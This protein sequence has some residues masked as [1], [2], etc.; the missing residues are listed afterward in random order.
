MIT[1]NTS[2]LIY[3]NNSNI[4]SLSSD[5]FYILISITCLLLICY[6]IRSCNKYIQ[7]NCR[8]ISRE[9]NEMR[10]SRSTIDISDISDNSDNNKIVTNFD[11]YNLDNSNL[12]H[13]DDLP[14]YNEVVKDY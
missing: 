12:S 1:I 13:D 6:T 7:N 14:S 2:R 11:L 10:L 8:N 4:E 3:Q 5:E 9:H